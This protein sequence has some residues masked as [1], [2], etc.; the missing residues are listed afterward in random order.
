MER[1]VALVA[2]AL[3]FVILA[4]WW[5]ETRFGAQMAFSVLM[6]VSHLLAFA[7][8]AVLSFAITRGS[9]RSVNDYAK[10]DAQVDRYRQQTF[11]AQATGDAAM[12]RAAAQMNVIDARRVDRMA[13]DRAK[14]LLQRD[15]QEREPID[16]WQWDD[17]AEIDIDDE[18]YQNGWQ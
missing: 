17:D 9:L 2:I 18:P 14:I 11:K 7:G 12:R 5:I 15:R 6:G 10:L 13:Q 3:G 1:M 16:T 8:G 4:A